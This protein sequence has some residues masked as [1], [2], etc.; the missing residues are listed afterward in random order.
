MSGGAEENSESFTHYLGE[1][2][3]GKRTDSHVRVCCEGFSGIGFRIHYSHVVTLAFD[4]SCQGLD[5]LF[6][7][8]GIF[9]IVKYDGDSQI[10]L[11][12]FF[13]LLGDV[14]RLFKK[15]VLTRSDG[16]PGFADDII[17]LSGFVGH[18]DSQ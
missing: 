13:R 8:I 15:P 12:K 14:S 7:R 3:R 5:D 18:G 9:R 11:L 10:P 6:E 17:N 16:L 1:Q 2:G 4:S